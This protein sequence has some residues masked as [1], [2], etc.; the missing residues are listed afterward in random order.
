MKHFKEQADD[1]RT[2]NLISHEERKNFEKAVK[3]REPHLLKVIF[4][5]IALPLLAFSILAFL[6]PYVFTVVPV[7]ESQSC[8]SYFTIKSSMHMDSIPCG[9]KLT[10]ALMFIILNW[11]EII[12]FALLFWLIRNIKNEL[13][14][15]REIQI[16]L[17][18]WS[19][20]SIIYFSMQIASEKLSQDKS[21][22]QKTYQY[23]IFF[24]I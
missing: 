16:V 14:V 4:L 19:V 15:K 3:W 13:N 11:I 8:W 7:L 9:M 20:F 6:V 21:D 17:L 24:V 10:N 18:F 23:V 1:L 2:S 12:G 5:F 22:T